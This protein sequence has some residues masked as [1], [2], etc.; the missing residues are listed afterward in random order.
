[1]DSRAK[2]DKAAYFYHKECDRGIAKL[3]GAY[4]YQVWELLKGPNGK[5]TPKVVE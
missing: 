3:R 1:M 2:F 4:V 5:L